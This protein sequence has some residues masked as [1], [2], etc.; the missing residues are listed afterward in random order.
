MGLGSIWLVCSS[1]SARFGRSPA[2]LKARR[3]VARLGLE[4]RSGS[5]FDQH[6]FACQCHFQSF[7]HA[8]NLFYLV[9]TIFTSPRRF[10]FLKREVSRLVMSLGNQKFGIPRKYQNQIGI[11][12]F[13]PK[14]LGIFL[15]FYRH[16]ENALAKIW[17]NTSIFQQNKNRFGIWF[18][19][20]PFHWY[21]FGF[22][23]SFS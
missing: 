1:E 14:F 20:L 2:Q 6:P 13:C 15:A 22:G 16:F 18:L 10:Y 17:L 4:A 12:Y 21:R 5:R 9:R 23:L 11:W 3:I 19:W 7:N 8:V